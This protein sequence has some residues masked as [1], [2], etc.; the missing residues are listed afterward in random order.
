MIKYCVLAAL[1]VAS[2][3]CGAQKPKAD[4]KLGEP[5][6]DS[7]VAMPQGAP[8]VREEPTNPQEQPAEEAEPPAEGQ[9]FVEQAELD[10]FIDR[11][12]SYILTIVTVEPVHRNSQFQGYQIT[13]VTRGAREFMTPQ[14]RVGDIVT[15]VNGV[16]LLRPEDYMQAWRSLDKVGT[17]RVDFVR[18]NENMSAVWV[19]R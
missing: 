18:Q 3:A 5:P 19:V 17:I 9:A 14:L 11:G 1:V 7:K 16:R 10:E 8:V 13:D 6:E 15:H 12:P 2:T 4:E